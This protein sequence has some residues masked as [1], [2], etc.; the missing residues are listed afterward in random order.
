M[1]NEFKTKDGKCVPMCA[2]VC[3]NSFGV[4]MSVYECVCVCVIVS[5]VIRFES[6]ICDE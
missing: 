3:V 1:K 2:C 5:S 4:C 6:F